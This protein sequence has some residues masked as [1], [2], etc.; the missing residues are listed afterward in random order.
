MFH[1]PMAPRRLA[2][3]LRGRSILAALLGLT[4]SDRADLMWYAS[5]LASGKS[6]G[7]AVRLF[8]LLGLLWPGDEPAVLLGRGVC[9]QLQGALDEAERAYDAVLQAQPENVYAR[10]NRAEVRLIQG[11]NEAAGDDLTLALAALARRKGPA[12]L[13][14]RV[15]TLHERTL[16][17]VAGP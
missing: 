5:R 12:A 13:R 6:P 2:R 1:R 14:R 16:G 4:E 10:A 9:F 11:R 17:R 3:W 7:D 15:Q 8:D